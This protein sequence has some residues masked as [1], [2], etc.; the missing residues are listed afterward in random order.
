MVNKMLPGLVADIR[1]C[2]ICRDSPQ[3]QAL[4]HEPRPVL[5]ASATARIL[6]AGQA[7]GIRAHASG[8]PF[9][10]P[11]GDRLRQWLGTGPDI[12]YDPAR[13]AILP[14]GFCFPGYSASG[15]DLP[16]RPECAAAWRAR[17][18]A[19]MPRIELIACLG[20]HAARWHLGSAWPGSLG[21][22]AAGWRQ[23][24]ECSPPVFVLPHPSWR[25]NAWLKANP[26]FAAELLPVLRQAVAARL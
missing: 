22:A 23:W 4:P 24:L 13:I 5:Q 6:I 1:R 12:F 26:W 11:S 21:S 3:G 18:L 16:P 19:L 10:D 9:T 15:S 17:L 8:L 2:R 14:M 7:P 25:N 20:T